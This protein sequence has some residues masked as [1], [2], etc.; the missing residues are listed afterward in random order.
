MRGKREFCQ[1]VDD[2]DDGDDGV[3]DK[4]RR[5]GRPQTP[6]IKQGQLEVMIEADA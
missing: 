2:D 6:N 3:G 4:L 1:D 5:V